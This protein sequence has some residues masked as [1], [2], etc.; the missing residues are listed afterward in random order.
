V[1]FMNAKPPLGKCKSQDSAG[2]I[3]TATRWAKSGS[4]PE[5]KGEHGNVPPI[6]TIF[7]RRILGFTGKEKKTRDTPLNPSRETS[8]HP[9]SLQSPVGLH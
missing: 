2:E 8:L 1:I 6:D 3:A 7:S 9:L 4:W 5:K